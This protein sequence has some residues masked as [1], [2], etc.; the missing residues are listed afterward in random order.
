MGKTIYE[1][2][3]AK[4]GALLLS[5]NPYDT[6]GPNAF[7]AVSQGASAAS[8]N[9]ET[10]VMSPGPGANNN[11]DDNNQINGENN[12]EEDI[13]SGL[14]YNAGPLKQKCPEG[15][16]LKSIDGVAHCVKKTETPGTPAT[17]GEPNEN[18]EIYRRACGGKNDGSVGTDPVT[19]QTRTCTQSGEPDPPANQGSPGTGGT[20]TVS[21]N[22]LTVDTPESQQ[23]NMGY[24]QATNAN[25]A[26][27]SM[28]RGTQ[29]ET[30]KAL[31]DI[32]NNV[33]ANNPDQFQAYKD[34]RKKNMDLDGDG[35]IS[36][37]E[38]LKNTFTGNRQ[39]KKIKAMKDAGMISKDY[40]SLRTRAARETV[41]PDSEEQ[42][43]KVE[44]M[45]MNKY[46][47][48]INKYGDYKPASSEPMS[49]EGLETMDRSEIGTFDT[50]PPATSAEVGAAAGS[51]IDIV[52]SSG[53]ADAV[54]IDPNKKKGALAMLGAKQ[55]PYKAK[56]G[57]TYKA[58]FGRG[59][60][61]K[62]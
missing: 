40:E 30:R 4:K 33:R 26:R 42:A 18:V 12:N 54:V 17:P 48:P 9:K 5:D 62:S 60:G 41:N 51:N 61:Y 55:K 29:R 6:S 37:K 47:I 36:L 1:K 24:A 35:K 3:K 59:P 25:W 22:P 10:Y 21:A 20:R 34:A 31:K 28:R 15:Q 2:I 13:S 23:F 27:G 57:L 44:S 50:P 11:D 49:G 39:E 16:E 43:Q 38:R 53:L 7:D 32:E 14:N 19:G 52:G 45:T 58:K 56:G 8:S 46:N